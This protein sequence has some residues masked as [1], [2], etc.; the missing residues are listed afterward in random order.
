MKKEMVSACA[1]CVPRESAVR[2]LRSGMAKDKLIFTIV[3]SVAIG[4]A[5]ITMA[6]SLFPRRTVAAGSQLWQCLECDD[7]FKKKTSELPPIDCP[8]GHPGQ[9][10]ALTYRFCPHCNEDV[11]ES[12]WRFTAEGKA[13]LLEYDYRFSDTK[14]PIYAVGRFKP[15]EFLLVNLLPLVDPAG[16]SYRLIIAPATMIKVKGKDNMERSVHG[17]FK[18][19]MPIEEFLGAYSRLGGT[20]HLALTYE[21]SVR[22][23]EAF[24]QMMGWDTVILG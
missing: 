10:V 9:A 18:T 5:V 1:G 22:L 20:H 2:S 17:W 15:G 16:D 23:I 13:R 24:G 12:R 19:G 11:L 3:C 6:I 14:N 4:V 7:I 8:K 21:P